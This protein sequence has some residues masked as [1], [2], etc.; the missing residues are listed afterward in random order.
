MTYVLVVWYITHMHVFEMHPQHEGGGIYQ[1]L[2]QCV[3]VGE[4]LTAMEKHYRHRYVRYVC[5][6]QL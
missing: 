2:E 5:E 1:T 4:T 6:M 3:A